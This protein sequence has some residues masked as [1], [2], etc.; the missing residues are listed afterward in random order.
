MKI[1][2]CC[3]L[4]LVLP[5]E[6][7]EKTLVFVRGPGTKTGFRDLKCFAKE[8]L[9][10]WLNLK[11][12]FPVGDKENPSLPSGG[13]STVRILWGILALAISPEWGPLRADGQHAIPRGFSG[14]S[15][16]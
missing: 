9:K 14:V 10:N 11:T 4:Q 3:P 2:N 16:I 7:Y 5:T 8:N 12:T 1:S 6:V 15:F 13:R